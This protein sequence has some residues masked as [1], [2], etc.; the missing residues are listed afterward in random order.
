V[1]HSSIAEKNFQ[2]WGWFG[3]PQSIKTIVFELANSGP[4]A[5]VGIQK[6]REFQLL[7]TSLASANSRGGAAVH[8]SPNQLAVVHNVVDDDDV[9]PAATSAT[10]RNKQDVLE[11]ASM[12]LV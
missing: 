9:A 4:K 8:S 1:V 11:A 3:A 6:A 2:K 10:T 7:V 5:Y 12:E